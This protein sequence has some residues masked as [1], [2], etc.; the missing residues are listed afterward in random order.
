MYVFCTCRYLKPYVINKT[1][2]EEF[3]RF[4][5]TKP[6]EFSIYKKNQSRIA[7]LYKVDSISIYII[8]SPQLHKL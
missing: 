6:L 8:I 2:V 4:W 1:E 7:V 5:P 3:Q